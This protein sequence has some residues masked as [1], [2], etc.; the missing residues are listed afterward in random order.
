MTA[1]P[2]PNAYTRVLPLRM[3]CSPTI[4][5]DSLK[6]HVDSA[7]VSPAPGPTAVSD[8]GQEGEH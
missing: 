8:A 6:P 2:S 5:V 3:G 4:N 7:C 1:C